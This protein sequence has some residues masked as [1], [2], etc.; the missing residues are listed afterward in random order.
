MDF[1]AVFGLVCLQLGKYVPDPLIIR[2][3][4]KNP[5]TFYLSLILIT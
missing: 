5:F 4:H 1:Y 2:E 3:L